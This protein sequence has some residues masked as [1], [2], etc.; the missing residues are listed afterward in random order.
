MPGV[1]SPF[2]QGQTGCGHG[3][4]AMHMASAAGLERLEFQAVLPGLWLQKVVTG[5]QAQPQGRYPCRGTLSDQMKVLDREYSPTK[6]R[7]AVLC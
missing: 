1:G 2:S 7:V 3:L 6:R 5:H 4:Q